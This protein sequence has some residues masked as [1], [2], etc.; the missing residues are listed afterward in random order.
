MLIQQNQLDRLMSSW[1][2]ANT[3]T[4]PS[5]ILLSEHQGK[6]TF[7]KKGGILNFFIR[8][9]QKNDYN[10]EANAKK[11][12]KIAKDYFTASAEITD[13]KFFEKY[14][15]FQEDYNRFVT[16]VMEKKLT[17]GWFANTILGKKK[18]SSQEIEDKTAKHLLHID[19]IPC[20]TAKNIVVT[21]A[22]QMRQLLNNSFPLC[23]SLTIDKKLDKDNEIN[24]DML[25]KI[26]INFPNLKILDMSNHESLMLLRG[27][28]FNKLEKAIFRN[29]V[30]IFTL[31]D[32]MRSFLQQCGSTLK[33]LDVRGAHIQDH[34]LAEC[35]LEKLE[36]LHL[37]YCTIYDPKTFVST[38]RNKYGNTLKEITTF[39][40]TP[41]TRK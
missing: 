41:L 32:E 1:E 34:T 7:E 14:K 37:D 19:N 9:F 15:L 20:A 21:S 16:R 10:F 11:I 17:P 39:C 8:L 31:P 3:N 36:K 27:C 35:N 22:S 28:R 12:K 13:S 24:L 26:S 25:Q 23:E 33:E 30:N 40:V 6:L 29:C 4:N 18:L 38:L 5:T 2:R